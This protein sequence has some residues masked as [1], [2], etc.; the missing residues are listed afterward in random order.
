MIDDTN[1][2]YRKMGDNTETQT[3]SKLSME[4]LDSVCYYFFLVAAEII[5][6][7]QLSCRFKLYIVPIMY[8]CAI[9]Y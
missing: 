8:Y 6:I 2:S 5:R 1:E 3:L 4:F 7:T 9:C